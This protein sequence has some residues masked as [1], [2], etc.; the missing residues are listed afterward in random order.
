MSAPAF[1]IGADVWPGLAKVVEEAGELLQVAG[2]IIALGG[3]TNYFD[4]T[5]LRSRL[6]NELADLEAAISY[7]LGSNLEELDLDELA[8]RSEAKFELFERW[9]REAQE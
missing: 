5:D 7:L 4:G 2:K 9:H 8:S 1:A 3:E 6:T